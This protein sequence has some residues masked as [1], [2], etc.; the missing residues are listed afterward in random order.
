MTIFHYDLDKIVEGTHPLKKV[1]K[2]ISF[3]SMMYRIKDVETSLGRTGY[4]LEVGL[5]C[6][7]LQF[8][9]DM[10][11]RQAEERI[12]YNMAMRWFLG[13]EI[14]DQTPDHSFFGRTRKTLGTSRIHKLLQVINK[15]AKKKGIMKE[16]FVFADASAIKAKETTWSQR[17]KALAQGE[18]KLNNDNIDKHSSDKDARFGCKGKNK[19]WYGYK[20]N[21]SVDMCSGLVDKTAVTPANIPDEQAFARICPKNSIVFADKA[22][23]LKPAQIAMKINGCVS[24][25]ILKKNM[26][27]KNKDQDRWRAQLRAPYENIFS[28]VNHKTRYRGLAKVQMQAVLEALVFN[29]NRLIKLNS[30]PLFVGA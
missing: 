29:V 23:C 4:G 17:D 12:R 14:D 15:K 30:P 21:S 22:Y 9:Y 7:F 3:K 10:S 6:L 18:E 19:F 26:L 28:K 20:R 13:F 2:L 27:G 1:A 25:A 11:D 5:K 8:F 16:L 24:A